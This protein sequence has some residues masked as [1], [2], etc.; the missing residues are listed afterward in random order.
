MSPI[1]KR[2]VFVTMMLNLRLYC[3][4]FYSLQPPLAAWVWCAVPGSGSSI[5]SAPSECHTDQA[6]TGCV[7]GHGTTSAPRTPPT[8][9]THPSSNAASCFSGVNDS[10]ALAYWSWSFGRHRGDR[11]QG[12]HL[13]RSWPFGSWVRT[14]TCRNRLCYSASGQV[15]ASFTDQLLYCHNLFERSGQRRVQ[16]LF[17]VDP[18]W[19]LH[20]SLQQVKS[21]VVFDDY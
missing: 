8:S 18:Y 21:I 4:L 12:Y 19:W 11:P 16:H 6:L 14:I 7:K 2:P 17:S 10:W 15:V 9:P 1:L 3:Q 5:G 13:A 20:W